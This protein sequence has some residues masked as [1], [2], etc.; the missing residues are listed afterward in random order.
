MSILYWALW[1]VLGAFVYA[2]PRVLVSWADSRSTDKPM[3]PHIAEFLI[4][5][6]FGPIFSA[7]FG[8]FVAGY[9]TRESSHE[10]RAIALVIGMVANPASP[11]VVK[12]ITGRLVGSLKGDTAK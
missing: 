3:L 7:G 1:G 6:T 8:P 2:A 12:L 10:L 9:L 5:L 4:S 11:L